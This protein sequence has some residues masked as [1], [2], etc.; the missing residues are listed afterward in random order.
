MHTRIVLQP[1]CLAAMPREFDVASPRVLLKHENELTPYLDFVAYD[2]IDAIH[3][4]TK[5][6]AG[7]DAAREDYLAAMEQGEPWIDG[8]LLMA[9]RVVYEAVPQNPYLAWGEAEDV[10]WCFRLMANGFLVDLE[11]NAVAH[12]QTNKMTPR[13]LRQGL[14]S[15]IARRIVRRARNGVRWMRLGLNRFVGRS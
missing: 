11:P 15:K 2:R 5:L 1:G 10:D 9:R 12:S 3:V 7:H 8:G 14:A 6:V 13:A 4:P